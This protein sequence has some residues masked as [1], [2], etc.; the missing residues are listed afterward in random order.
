[1]SR[2]Y[3]VLPHE[4]LQDGFY[5]A[6]KCV[7]Q[8]FARGDSALNVNYA[9]GNVLDFNSEQERTM[10]ARAALEWMEATE[11]VVC[12]IDRG[13]DTEMKGELERARTRGIPI[14]FRRL[15]GGRPGTESL[16]FQGIPHNG[17]D[18]AICLGPERVAAARASN[19]LTAD[20]AEQMSH[21]PKPKED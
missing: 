5:F 15:A 21:L 18:C 13:V 2:V 3:L 11:R 17:V 12:Y 4:D 9:F 19:D 1:L 8:C 16:H 14:E 7:L 10:A 6:R 20:E